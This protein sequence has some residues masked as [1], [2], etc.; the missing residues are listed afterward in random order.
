MNNVSLIGR[1]TRDAE[2][3]YTQS[4]DAIASFTI[5]VNGMG[6]DEVHFIDCEA[7]KKT[8]E[9]IQKFFTKGSQ[10]AVEGRLKQDRWEKDGKKFNKLKV[11]V[12]QITFIGK[13]DDNEN[14]QQKPL[15]NNQHDDYNYG[16]D[17]DDNVPY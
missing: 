6:K 4:G 5:A 9:L 11:V 7:W 3:K 12:N 15:V 8:A 10:I 16:T 13:R 14:V 1:L 2:M 17:Y